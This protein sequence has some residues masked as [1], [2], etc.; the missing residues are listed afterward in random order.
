MTHRRSAVLL[1][2]IGAGLYAQSPQVGRLRL[3]LE[4]KQAWADEEYLRQQITWV[5]WVRDPAGAHVQ[6]LLVV[7]PAGGGGATYTLRFLGLGPFAGIDDRFTYPVPP[8][9]TPD[10]V[11][12]G[13]AT[14]LALG[15]ARYAA[16]MDQADELELQARPGGVHGSAI[17]TVDPWK[18]WVHRF[19]ANGYFSG[20]SR[21]ASASTSVN[22]GSAKV[23]AEDFYRVALTGAWSQSRFSLEDS[24]LRTGSEAYSLGGAAAWALSDRWTWGWMGGALRSPRSNVSSQVRIGP[25]LEYNLWKYSDSSQR[26]LTFLYRPGLRRSVYMEETLFGRTRETITDQTFTIALDLNQPWGTV[27]GSLSGSAFLGDWSRNS[28]GLYAGM[29]LRVAKGLSLNLYFSYSR[30]RDQVALPRSGASDEDVL[31]RRKELATDYRYYA[32]LGISYTFGS[33]FNSAVNS[34]FRNAGY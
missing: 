21:T 18:G 13:L 32:S 5:D 6:I 8:A 3:C 19:Q 11:R 24:V 34:R 1:G 9:S 7:E 12:R 2:L 17:A 15:L 10:L 28:L 31:L 27:S 16:R 29:D 20:E 25:A 26:Q 30:V 4:L 14:R 22:A 23:T 33:I